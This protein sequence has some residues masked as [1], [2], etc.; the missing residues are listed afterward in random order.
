MIM[1]IYNS[2]FPLSSELYYNFSALFSL[3][4]SS[5]DNLHCILGISLFFWCVDMIYNFVSKYLS[6]YLLIHFFY[7]LVNI[8][9]F[10]VI[11]LFIYYLYVFI[12][13]YV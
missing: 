5:H 9:I 11:H 6:I 1:D 13:I 12:F 10:V 4:F 2:L 3:L 7:F 8:L